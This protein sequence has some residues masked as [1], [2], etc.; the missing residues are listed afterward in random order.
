MHMNIYKIEKE[1]NRNHFA[2]HFRHLNEPR[3]F[4]IS[5]QWKPIPRIYP[6]VRGQTQ[7]W[8]C[9]KL[10]QLTFAMVSVI[11]LSKAIGAPCRP[12]IR[13]W[14]VYSLVNWAVSLIIKEIFNQLHMK[15][16]WVVS[17][18]QVFLLLCSWTTRSAVSWL[19][20]LWVSQATLTTCS[21]INKSVMGVISSGNS[22][23]NYPVTCWIIWYYRKICETGHRLNHKILVLPAEWMQ[24]R[25]VR[26]V[27]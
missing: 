20:L 18:N 2:Q 5:Q 8:A 22:Y 13:Q 4:T 19:A 26:L 1:I 21:N 23:P 6:F 9:H 14:A 15:N 24:H 11:G 25:Q 7:R 3:R 16:E 12:T 17:T 27:C 10:S